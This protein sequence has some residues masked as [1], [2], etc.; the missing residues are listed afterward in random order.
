MA[1]IT[2]LALIVAFLALVDNHVLHRRTDTKVVAV[3][4]QVL[5]VQQAVGLLRGVLN[6]EIAREPETAGPLAA[7]EATPQSR[8]P[9]AESS[10]AQEALMRALQDNSQATGGIRADDLLILALRPDNAFK[11]QDLVAALKALRDASRVS[12]DGTSEG[13]VK[14]T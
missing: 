4:D 6:T 9:V 12:W 1:L 5:N 2:V 11:T 14:A 8:P 10:S 7:T 3:G 13:Q